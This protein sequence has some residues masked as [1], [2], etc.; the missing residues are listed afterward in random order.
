MLKAKERIQAL[1][2][3]LK[4]CYVLVYFDTVF[5]F[6]RYVWSDNL[7]KYICYI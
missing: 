1:L 2:C 7:T 6:I 3:V 4:C 5:D